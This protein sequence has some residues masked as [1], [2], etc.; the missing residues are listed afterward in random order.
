VI[1]FGNGLDIII[2]V[3]GVLLVIDGVL[4]LLASLKK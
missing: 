2:M 1:A 4:G 3:C